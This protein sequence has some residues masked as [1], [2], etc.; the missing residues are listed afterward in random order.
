MGSYVENREFGF[1]KN[2]RIIII[3]EL[4]PKAKNTYR[5]DYQGRP[6]ELPVIEVPVGLLIYRIE[7][8]RTITAQE[9]Y[10]ATHINEVDP[11]FFTINPESIDVQYV[12]NSLLEK[13]LDDK[14]LFS[15][16]EKE[17]E[18]GQQQPLI[19]TDEGVVV[20]GNRRL[21]AWRKLLRENEK[22]YASFKTID[23][24]VLPNHDPD[25]LEDLE[26]DLQLKKDIKAEYK[27]HAKAKSYII[28]KENRNYTNEQLDEKYNYPNGTV[29]NYIAIYNAAKKYLEY[30]NKQNQ[31][32]EVDKAEFAFKQIVSSS[33]KCTTESS[34]M[35]GDIFEAVA[36]SI[37][38]S[39]SEKSLESAGRLYSVI[40]DI[41]KYTPEIINELKTKTVKEEFNEMRE[42]LDEEIDDTSI[43]LK[44]I[45]KTD[46][47]IIANSAIRKIEVEK[48]LGKESKSKNA[49]IT[50]IKRA[51]DFLGKAVTCDKSNQTKSGVEEQLRLLETNIQALRVWLNDEN[52]D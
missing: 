3:N 23:V 17:R 28:E 13:M 10:C 49:V 45:K 36:Y 19:I 48:E 14:D 18:K 25:A 33:K 50:N 46:P 37:I 22:K 7:N 29:E 52:N 51:A 20:N 1:P 5:V 41:A 2:E 40:P 43:L 31:W 12:Q 42:S 38:S 35:Q 16:F 6:R 21:C 39:N 15:S 32:S 44:V 4:L 34:F 11:D 9:E 8:F 26:T 47:S 24:A 30:I 27:W